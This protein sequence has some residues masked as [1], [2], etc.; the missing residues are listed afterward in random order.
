MTFYFHLNIHC[1]QDISEEVNNIL[2]IKME[3]ECEDCKSKY[4]CKVCNKDKL[5]CEHDQGKRYCEEFE[6]VGI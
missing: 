6:G 2:V 3:Y 5:I 1:I 4:S